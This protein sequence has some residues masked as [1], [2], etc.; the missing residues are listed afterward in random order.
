MPKSDLS[1]DLTPARREALTILVAARPDRVR[2]SNTTRAAAGIGPGA[3]IPLISWKTAEWLTRSG[4]V[5]ELTRPEGQ[6]IRLAPRGE[7]LAAEIGLVAEPAPAPEA[8]PVAPKEV[9]HREAPIV[10]TFDPPSGPLAMGAL[11]ALVVRVLECAPGPVG[12]VAIGLALGRSSGAVTNVLAK[13][14]AQGAVVE[15][16][17][18]PRRFTIAASAVAS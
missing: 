15:T 17:H 8:T 5:D 6:T 11:N 12:P 4:L 13:L 2:V 14:T 9:R 1:A 18:K 16:S 3:A 10:L 7:K